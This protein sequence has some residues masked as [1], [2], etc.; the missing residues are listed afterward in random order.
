MK[1]ETV[2]IPLFFHICW[3]SIL[4]KIYT[5]SVG[6]V[7]IV[8]TS[9]KT[10]LDETCTGLWLEEL[11]T[12]YYLFKE[13]GLEVDIA[14]IAGGEIPIDPASLGSKESTVVLQDKELMHHLE[15]SSSVASI[16]ASSIEKYDALFIPGG[17]GIVFDGPSSQELETIIQDMVK[18]NKIIASVCH[19]PAAFINIKTEDGKP[20]VEGRPICSFTDSEEKSAE[21]D[22]KVPFLIESKLREL[23]GVFE[24]GADWQEH[25]TKVML[26][27]GGGSLITG[28]NPASAAMVAN[29][30]CEA[31]LPSLH[32]GDDD[33]IKGKGKGEGI[34]ARG[35]P[36]ARSEHHE[37]REGEKFGARSDVS[38]HPQAHKSQWHQPVR[39]HL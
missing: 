2:D 29:M 32:P 21:K 3:H 6:K 1:K 28:Q 22:K 8:A 18:K 15:N 30:V 17:H 39:Q 7:L 5:M 25:A 4:I 34:H 26:E 20:L 27:G 13:R 11:T 36:Y 19:G 12:P 35:H 16:L 24:C 10:L 14:S 31:I 37:H 38:D 23:G 9:H 33:D